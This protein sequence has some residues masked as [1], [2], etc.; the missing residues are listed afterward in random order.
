M[1]PPAPT[2]AIPPIAVAL[3]ANPPVIDAPPDNNA[4]GKL[5]NVARNLLAVE[6]RFEDMEN[7]M[8]KKA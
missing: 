7:Y 6:M 5:L 3:V 4:E 8:V 2:A 1:P